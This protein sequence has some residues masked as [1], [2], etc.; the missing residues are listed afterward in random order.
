M[1]EDH[2]HAEPVR[3]PDRRPP[4]PAAWV[5]I[6]FAVGILAARAIDVAWVIPVATAV[7]LLACS[8]AL[9]RTERRRLAMVC[10]V[11]MSLLL[12][13]ADPAPRR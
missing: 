7:V 8:I 11:A 12:G 10:L 4:L 9:V 5:A 1:L 13:F 2:R 6:P 3:Q